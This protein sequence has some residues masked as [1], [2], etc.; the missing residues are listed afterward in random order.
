MENIY[1]KFI[2]LITLFNE[3]DV[4]YILIGGMA[5]NLHGFSRN[6]EDIDIFVNPTKENINRFRKSLFDVFQD[7][8]IEEIT[9]EE[10]NKYPIIRYGTEYGFSIDVITQI[11]EKFFFKDLSYDVKTL[12]G[13]E[14]KFADLETLY[15]LK[16]KTYR[17]INQLD[18]EFIKSKLDK[19]A[20]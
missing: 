15:K 14:V 6:T 8:D 10:L 16:E 19:N 18:L 12:D 9:I 4:E 17:E 2:E 13:K 11:G 1:N 5:I 7:K 20:N 3:N